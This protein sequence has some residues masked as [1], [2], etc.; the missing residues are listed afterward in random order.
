MTLCTY[1]GFLKVG[2]SLK[3][4]PTGSTLDTVEGVFYWQVGPGFYGTYELVFLRTD[5]KGTSTIKIPV[6][7]VAL[8]AR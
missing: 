3:P 1:S 5:I 8:P 6:N 4:L 7:V 2:D